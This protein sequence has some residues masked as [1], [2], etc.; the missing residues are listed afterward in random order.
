MTPNPP[1]SPS[2]LSSEPNFNLEKQ[3][4]IAAFEKDFLRA[5]L[6]ETKGNITAAARNSGMHKKNFIQKMQQYG[7]KREDFME[8]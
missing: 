5:R 8:K 2:H 6:R 4:M 3:N 7:L 1:S